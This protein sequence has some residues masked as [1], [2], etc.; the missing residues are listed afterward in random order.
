MKIKDEEQQLTSEKP[1][2]RFSQAKYHRWEFLTLK[3]N[4]YRIII[5]I[6][7]IS[8][9]FFHLVLISTFNKDNG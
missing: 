7:L 2:W 6:T 5:S 1:Q 9:I 4:D 8:S 3:K